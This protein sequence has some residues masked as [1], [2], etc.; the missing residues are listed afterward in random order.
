MS[1]NNSWVKPILQTKS[2]SLLKHLYENALNNLVVTFYLNAISEKRTLL[3]ISIK[4]LFSEIYY[5]HGQNLPTKQLYQIITM[6]S[7]GTIPT[8]ASAKTRFST[9]SQ[10]KN[11][12]KTL[13]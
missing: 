9:N 4:N 8:F 13:I 10:E 3:N 12:K 2:N 11:Q 5:Y 7:F 6:K 1:L